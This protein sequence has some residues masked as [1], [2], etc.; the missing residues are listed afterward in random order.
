[1]PPRGALIADVTHHHQV[2]VAFR[3]GQPI[4]L[5]VIPRNRQQKGIREIKVRILDPVGCVI[6]QPERQVKPVE[7]LNRQHV[8]IAIPEPAVVVPGLVLDIAAKQPADPAHRVGRSLDRRLSRRKGRERFISEPNALRN[9]CQRISE[10][11]RVPAK[12][13]QHTAPILISRHQR[14]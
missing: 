7:P 5:Y 4:G 10:P 1:M 2:V 9:L 11:A 13:Q 12:H 3:V 6:P 8:E 14:Q